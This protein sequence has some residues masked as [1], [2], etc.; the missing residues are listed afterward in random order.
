MQADSKPISV[1]LADDHQLVRRGL[2]LLLA[3]SEDIE[4]VGEA[5]TAEEA[6]EVVRSQR[7][8]VLV[9]DLNMPGRPTLEVLAEL[10]RELPETGVVVLT[11]EQDPGLASHAIELGARGYLIKRTVEDELLSAIR[12]LAAGGEHISDEVRVAINRRK[13]EEQ[14]PGRL[15]ERELEVL[16]MIALGHTHQEV[17]DQLGISVRT[18]ESHRMHIMQKANLETR[19]DLVRYALS[20]GII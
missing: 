6:L 19:P 18:V 9:L 7:P 10:T 1:V 5:G 2:G 13:R 4:L 15:T 8:D 11:M 17:A 14:Q 20:E 16:K 3:R 12:T